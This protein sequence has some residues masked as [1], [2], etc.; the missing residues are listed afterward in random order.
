LEAN[1]L[2]DGRK[3]P[4][5]AVFETALCIVGGGTSA[6][7]LACNLANSCFRVSLLESGGLE[8]PADIDD[9]RSEN[10]GRRFLRARNL[11]IQLSAPDHSTTFTHTLREPMRLGR[12]W[13]SEISIH[14]D[15][16]VYLY[17]TLVNIETDG[18]SSV[19]RLQAASLDGNRFWIILKY[20]ILAGGRHPDGQVVRH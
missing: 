5:R 7:R 15:V 12:A 3:V 11:Q 20:F 4:E 17:S 9:P 14:S 2:V 10:M 1:V 6:I 13:Q 19:I 8:Q 18:A 16:S